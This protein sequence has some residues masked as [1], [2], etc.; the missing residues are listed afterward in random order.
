MFSSLIDAIA[1]LMQEISASIA[2]RISQK[3]R[4]RNSPIVSVVVQLLVFAFLVVPIFLAIVAS[5]LWVLA[6]IFFGK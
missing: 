5:F 4:I 6:L 1:N 2:F 3:F